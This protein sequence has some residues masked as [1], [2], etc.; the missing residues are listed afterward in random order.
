MTR[1]L[2]R[3]LAGIALCAAA[4]LLAVPGHAG[5][6]S[7]RPV[8]QGS[9][10]DNLSAYDTARWMKADNWANGSPFPNSWLASHATFQNDQ[11]SFLLDN[12]GTLGYS[13]A[14]GEYRTTGFYGYGCYE[15]SFQAVGQ[16]GVVSSFFTFAGPYDNGG[17]G[18]HNEIDVEVLGDKTWYA[19]L[20]YWT[21]DDTYSSHN[22]YLLGLGFDASKGA[23]RYGFKWTSTYIE[24][25]VD[26]NPLYKVIDSAA[27]PIPK[28]ADSLQKIMMNLWP[29]DSSASLWAGSFVYAGPV[30]STYDWVRYVAGE[31]CTFPAPPAP[32]P[33]GDATKMHVLSVSTGL[34]SRLTQVIAKATV[35]DGL[36]RAVAGVTVGG[37]WSGAITSGDTGR[38]TDS[39]GVATF[40]SS[41]SR[42]TGSV[43]FCVNGVTGGSL[44]LDSSYSLPVCSSVTK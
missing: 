3:R 4:L 1:R 23:H 34:N 13:F 37:A 42:A 6:P 20:N 18:K 11:L 39:N 41:Q 35:V 7:P 5:K 14:S 10:T 22:E 30:R 8:A 17:N 27:A 16:P 26:G 19:Q 15:T 25:W 9:F 29:V 43:S 36:G 33:T 28:A 38:T 32:P 44:A 31:D 2:R 40:Y 12:Q 21:N 24:W